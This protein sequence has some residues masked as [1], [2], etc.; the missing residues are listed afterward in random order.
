MTDVKRPDLIGALF[1]DYTFICSAYIL[2]PCDL[3]WRKSGEYGLGRD[4][5]PK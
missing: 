4:R 3:N 5:L 1:R 2:E